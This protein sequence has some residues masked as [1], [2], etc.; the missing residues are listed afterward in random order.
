[1]AH[2]PLLA[3][4]DSETTGLQL[5]EDG[6]GRIVELA[7]VLTTEHGETVSTF[8]TLLNP[9]RPIPW[10]ATMVH[11]IADE[12]V[13]EAP[14]MSEVLPAF[15]EFLQPARMIW[16]FNTPFDARWLMHE[17]VLEAYDPPALDFYDVAR[18]ASYAGL[19]RVSLAALVETVGAP[20]MPSHRALDDAVATAASLG[21]LLR[22]AFGT[23][24]DWDE[25]VR[26]HDRNVSVY[27]TERAL[28]SVHSSA[29]RYARNPSEKRPAHLASRQR[30]HVATGSRREPELPRICVTGALAGVLRKE[31]RARLEAVGYAYCEEPSRSGVE[32]M[33]VGARAAERK[34]QAADTMEIPTISG[35]DFLR[36]LGAR[37]VG[38][39]DDRAST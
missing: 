14:T 17:C 15:F 19:G 20:V 34:V 4:F 8:Q 18:I 23:P 16:G 28:S 6:P 24:V 13:V 26:A 36:W 29:K 37:E 11:G 25:V 1:M 39:N 30:H 5:Y 3:F 31:V 33:V 9:Q 10:P 7:G 12:D 2:E 38:R 27:H 21:V 32:F 35:T 22:D